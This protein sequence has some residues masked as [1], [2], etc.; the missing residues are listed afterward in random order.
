MGHHLPVTFRLHV[1]VRG[2][3]H[4]FGIEEILLHGAQGRGR[5]AGQPR[6]DGLDL[7]GEVFVVEHLAHESHGQRVVGMKFVRQEVDLS[8]LGHPHQ[9]RQAPRARHVAGRG[10]VQKRGVEAGGARGEAQITGTRPAQSGPGA[11]A[12]DCGD[13]HLQAAAA[14]RPPPPYGPRR[15]AP[16]G[17]GQSPSKPVTC[18][19]PPAA[20]PR[21]SRPGFAAHAPWA[22]RSTRS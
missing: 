16:T 19:M 1:D 3:L 8:S 2:E 12:V 17:S 15:P 6:G 9:S 18:I 22:R 14:P 7:G 21:L 11:G 13:G 4:G 10:Q 5:R 20:W